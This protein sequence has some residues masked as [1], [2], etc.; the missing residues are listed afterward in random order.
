MVQ[1]R[2]AAQDEIAAV[3]VGDGQ[4]PGP[5]GVQLDDSGTDALHRE[6][7]GRQRI[8]AGALVPD[9]GSF[10]RASRGLTHLRS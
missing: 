6:C 2:A 3:G 9:R 8:R 1:G 10:V 5:V 7:H 4:V